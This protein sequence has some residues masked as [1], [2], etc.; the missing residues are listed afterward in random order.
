MLFEGQG[1]L[2]FISQSS[3]SFNSILF[4]LSLFPV[5][6]NMGQSYRLTKKSLHRYNLKSLIFKHS[7]LLIHMYNYTKFEGIFFL[8]KFCSQM[9]Y[10]FVLIYFF[11]TFPTT[12]RQRSN[13]QPWEGL[14]NSPLPGTE[15]IQMP[16]GLPRE[17]EREGGVKILI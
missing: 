4:F 11:S 5:D 17:G 14:S 1:I 16:G 7:L 12:P 2:R 6:T 8:S 10:L 15:N 3:L 9:P 13:P